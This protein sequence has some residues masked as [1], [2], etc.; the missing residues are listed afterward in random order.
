MTRQ[1]DIDAAEL[2]SVCVSPD[3]HGLR[4]RVRDRTGRASLV[5][6]PMSW[7]NTI[8]NALPRRP[9]DTEVHPLDSWNMDRAPNG[10]DLVLTL[11][12]PEGQA[13]SF[14]MK[15]WQVEGMATIATYGSGTG[16]ARTVH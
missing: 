2:I 7:L 10:Q 6:L 3:G 1:P 16:P 11:R 8:L 15:S 9:N 14:T 5:A 12:T 4:L 13:V